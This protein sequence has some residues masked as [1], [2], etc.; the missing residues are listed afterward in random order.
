ME[1][2][3]CLIIAL[4]LESL[5]NSKNDLPIQNNSFNTYS[6]MKFQASGSALN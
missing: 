4:M 5:A 1:P 2:Q 6:E 3:R